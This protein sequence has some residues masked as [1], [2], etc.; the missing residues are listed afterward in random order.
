MA[1]DEVL[2]QRLREILAD[3][4]SIEEKRMCG[5]LTPAR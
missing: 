5:G 2:A 4:Y 1:Y 3:R